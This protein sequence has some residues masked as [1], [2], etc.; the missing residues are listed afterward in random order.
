MPEQVNITVL[1]VGSSLLAPLKKAEGEINARF[2]FA[3]RVAA[4][5]C[6]A[7]LAVED[8]ERVERDLPGSDLVFIIHVTDEENATRIISALGRIEGRAPAVIAFNCMLDLMRQ[9][10]MGR[11]DFNSLM[12]QGGDGNGGR[13]RQVSIRNIVK[14]LGSWMADTFKG[15]RESREGKKRAD[16]SQYVRLIGR[17]PSV[18]KLV[19]GAGR[20]KDLKNY[21]HLFCYFLQPTP[22]NIR[23]MLLYAIRHYVPGC[24]VEEKLA[25]PESLP[26]EAIYHP[27]A[28]GLFESFD[29]YRKWYER[30]FNRK[31]N[32]HSTIGLL[33]MRPQVVSDSRRHYDC[34]IRAIE[35]EGLAVIPALSTFM[36]NRAACM[37]FF[38]APR[39]GG[40]GDAEK[41]VARVSQVVSLTGFSFVGGPAMNDSEAAS[42]FLRSLNVPYRS[43][44]SLDVQTIESW[45]QSKLGLNTVQSAMQVAIPEIDGATE[46]FIFGGITEAG[47]EPV[48]VEERCRRIARRLSRWNR[49]QVLPRSE[50]RLALVIFCFPPNKGNIGTAADLDVFPSLMQILA[51]LKSDGYQ[52]E[53]P[54]SGDDLRNRM[55]EGNAS[56]FGSVANVAHR[57]SVDEYRRIFPFVRDIEREWGRAPGSI[58]SNGSELLIQ[59]IVL[60]NVLIGVQP[61]FG[62][63][64]DPMRLL[65]A[66]SSS[67]HHAFAALYAYIDKIFRADT[68]IH[69]GTHGALEFMPGKQVGLNASCWPDRLMGDLPNVY[70]YS[71]NNP[72]EGAIAKRR[73][74]A[75]LISYLTPPV[76]NAG[77]YKD[78]VSLKE[79][80]AAYRRAVAEDEKEQLYRLIEEKAEALNLP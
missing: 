48:P 42:E 10:R 56:E 73:S 75:E 55:L 18:L 78:L 31:L 49:L 47:H 5:N 52:V 22:N 46:P 28:G 21:L 33:V 2:P 71:V 76:E 40:E 25:P 67:P 43:L 50:L 61:T 16:H 11:L 39:R 37:K 6:G 62:Y 41:P 74:Y 66:E 17:L 34:L 68:V 23:S 57:M 64:G 79:L 32:P 80:L 1:Y 38:T 58:N 20:L 30:R 45:R 51:G 15:G 19:P 77:L 26:A 9:T 24:E 44:V 69:V 65:M 54:R 12:K 63:E 7:A 60:G 3:V 4:H 53:M 72:A 8:W 14:K 13:G 29:S 70:L 35:S 59:G 36:D 27:D